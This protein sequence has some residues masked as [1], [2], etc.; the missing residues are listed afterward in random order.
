MG[1][2]LRD[3]G[4]LVLGLLVAG[5]A[6]FSY[7]Y[8]GLDDADYTRGTLRGPKPEN[9]LKFERC[10]PTAASKHPCVV[11]F[12]TEFFKFKADYEDTKMRLIECERGRLQ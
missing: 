3:C 2:R 6:G 7:K 10:A 5:C 1:L 12:A 4:F 8:Y 9:D 11:L